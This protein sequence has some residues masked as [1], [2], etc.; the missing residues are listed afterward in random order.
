MVSAEPDCHAAFG[1]GSE[2]LAESG[3]TVEQ[4]CAAID[5]DVDR[6]EGSAE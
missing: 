4:E 5:Q 2:Q 1:G 3:D 6:L